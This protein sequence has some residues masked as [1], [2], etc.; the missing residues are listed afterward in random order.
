MVEPSD[1]WPSRDKGYSLGTRNQTQLIYN[2]LMIK[3]LQ[4]D[5]IPLRHVYTEC[6]RKPKLELRRKPQSVLY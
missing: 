5:P 3:G 2:H 1:S 4:L 6:K